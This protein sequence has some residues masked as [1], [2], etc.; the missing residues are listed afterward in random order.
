MN[1]DL[2]GQTPVDISIAILREFE[3]RFRLMERELAG[4]AGSLEDCTLEEMERAWQSAKLSGG[5]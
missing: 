2:F 4:S 5:S 1:S 3:R